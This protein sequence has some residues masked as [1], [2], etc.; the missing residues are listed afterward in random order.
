MPKS[1]SNLIKSG[2][3]IGL[4]FDHKVYID[5]SATNKE[6]LNQCKLLEPVAEKYIF[7]SDLFFEYTKQPPAAGFLKVSSNFIDS[8]S[9]LLL[10]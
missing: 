6:A 8:F 2:N 9:T 1:L 3:N 7:G 5:S 4:H 10:L